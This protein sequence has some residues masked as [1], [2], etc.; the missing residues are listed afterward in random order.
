[1]NDDLV[2][3]RSKISLLESNASSPCASSLLIL[4]N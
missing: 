3:A 2:N 4:I 1:L